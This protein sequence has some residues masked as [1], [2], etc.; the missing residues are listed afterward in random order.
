[1]ERASTINL[2]TSTKAFDK[3]EEEY[4]AKM[5]EY[6]EA[7]RAHEAYNAALHEVISCPF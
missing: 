5:A 2:Y 4:S 7:E 3:L 1:M 6:R